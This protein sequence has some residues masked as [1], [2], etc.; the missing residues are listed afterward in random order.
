MYQHSWS[1]YPSAR[2]GAGGFTFGTLRALATQ[3]RRE[4]IWAWL[5]LLLLLLC[6]DA[7]SRLD[8]RVAM[9]RPK[10]GHMVEL[11][12]EHGVRIEGK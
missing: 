5:S 3:R 2:T 4:H 9:P 6:W 11:D 10:L 1:R 7:S 8:D 12:P